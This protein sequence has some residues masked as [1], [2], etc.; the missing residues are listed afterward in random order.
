MFSLL[1][2]ED[3]RW[4]RQGLCET[5]DWHSEGIQEI[6]DAGDGEEAIQRIENGVPDIII[7][8]IRMPGMDGIALLQEIRRRQ[9]DSQ[10]IVISG[11][12]DF[13]YARIALRNGAADYVLKP[14]RKNDMISAV[15]RCIQKLMQDRK[16]REWMDQLSGALRESLPLARVRLLENLLAGGT[17]SVSFEP[18]RKQWQQMGIELDP[19]KIYTVVISVHHWGRGNIRKED[20]RLLLYALGN[21]AEEIGNRL[22]R[23]VSFSPGFPANSHDEAD[24]VLLYS[25]TT[26]AEKSGRITAL[27]QLIERAQELL[28]LTVTIG[29]SQESDVSTLP[30]AYEEAIHASARYFY[31]GVG[32]VYLSAGPMQDQTGPAFYYGPPGWDNRLVSALQTC[33]NRV[34]EQLVEELVDHMEIHRSRCCPLTMLR[35]LRLLLQ[36]SYQKTLAG[37]T[38]GHPERADQ[39]PPFELPPCT[40]DTVK[41]VLIDTIWLTDLA[42]LLDGSRKKISERALQFVDQRYD[43]GITLSD[44]AE[45]LELHPAYFSKMFHEEVGETFSKYII[46]Y[47]MEKAKQLLRETS[48]KIYEVSAQVGYN[49]VKYFTKLFKEAEGMSPAQYREIGI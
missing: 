6:W 7:T 16:N 37:Y 2:V 30:I 21:M 4:V 28:G 20:R 11:F 22:G 8:D 24:L 19:E 45:H 25:N 34:V 23:S 9:I 39:L 12:N 47:R 15:R 10:V 29:C 44:V 43:K 38:P 14:I 41:D 17:R 13:E 42:A 31:D 46:R 26:E 49:D 36:T 40:L 27:S 1:V 35:G 18:I 3:E 48:L 32:R 5:I 33:E